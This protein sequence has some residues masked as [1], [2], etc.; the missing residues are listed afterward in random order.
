MPKQIY[1]LFSFLLATLVASAQQPAPKHTDAALMTR[2]FGN[3]DSTNSWSIW[4]PEHIPKE[5]DQY[6]ENDRGR[7]SL[8]LDQIVTIGSIKKRYVVFSTLAD[9]G[10][11]QGLSC[12][13]SLA[14]RNGIRI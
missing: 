4:H 3:Y 1:F 10:G 9:G 11:Y 6:F 8:E 13:W 7:T 5:Y 2:L 12:L 14:E